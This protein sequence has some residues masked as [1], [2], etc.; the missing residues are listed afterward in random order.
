MQAEVRPLLLECGWQG[1]NIGVIMQSFNLSISPE[2]SSGMLECDI[3][4][5]QNYVLMIL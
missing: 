4:M 2:M 3:V 5:L 1:N